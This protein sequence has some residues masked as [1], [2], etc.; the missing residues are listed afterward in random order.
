MLGKGRGQPLVGPG[1]D[2]ENHHSA[3][4][5]IK[6]LHHAETGPAGAAQKLLQCGIYRSLVACR[7]RLGGNSGRLV[8]R[9]QVAVTIQD[10]RRIELKRFQ[11]QAVDKQFNPLSRRDRQA[12]A[13]HPPAIDM[14]S[15]QIDQALDRAAPDAFEN[16]AKE[17]VQAGA[18]LIAGHDKTVGAGGKRSLVHSSKN[19]MADWK[20]FT[21]MA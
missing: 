2:G 8:Q 5:T 1:M 3:G 10:H 7:R 13:P 12:A 19:R 21:N 9:Q 14:H 20:N 18:C 6:P 11:R 15:A 16:A 17:Q 4:V